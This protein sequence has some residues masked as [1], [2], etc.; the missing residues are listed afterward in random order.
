MDCAMTRTD[1]RR[2][3]ASLTLA[4]I[5]V[6]A[7]ASTPLGQTGGQQFGGKDLVA[8]SAI[9]SRPTQDYRLGH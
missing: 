8:A 1:D 9:A 3:V 5:V 7:F 4:S 2:L 6:P